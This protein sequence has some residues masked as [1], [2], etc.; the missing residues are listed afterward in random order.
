MGTK[1][2][3][4]CAPRSC[5]LS[6]HLTSC[7]QDSWAVPGSCWEQEGDRAVPS[8]FQPI[9]TAHTSWD[10][11]EGAGGSSSFAVPSL[12]LWEWGQELLWKLLPLEE[13]DKKGWMGFPCISWGLCLELAKLGCF[14]GLPHTLLFLALIWEE[15]VLIS[16]SFSFSQPAIQ[17]AKGF[18]PGKAAAASL[19]PSLFSCSQPGMG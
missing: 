14:W 9:P 7:L 17:Q 2:S 11:S 8:S 3:F 12:C 1:S 5:P 4:P 10:G 18:Q 16:W 6:S 13:E 15:Q 19:S